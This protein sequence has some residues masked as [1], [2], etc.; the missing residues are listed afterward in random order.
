MLHQRYLRLSRH[1]S[2]L[3]L[4]G[5]S[6]SSESGGVPHAAWNEALSTMHIDSRGIGLS[7]EYTL[8]P[9]LRRDCEPLNR[10]AV[11]DG[12]DLLTEKRML[13]TPTFR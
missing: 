6:A 9:W 8:A 13:A 11:A 10:S 5:P 7:R 12:R 1:E 3:A 4:R 2:S